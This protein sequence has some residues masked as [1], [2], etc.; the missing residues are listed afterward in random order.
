MRIIFIFLL[1]LSNN[2]FADIINI[3]NKKFR[4][5]LRQDIPVIDIRTKKE[6]IKTGVIKNSYLISMINDQG[7]YS[8]KDWYNKYSKIEL[9]DNKVI[10][11]C[12]VGGRSTYIS[13]ILN[14]LN[15]ETIIY[16]VQKGINDWINSDYPT[17][18]YF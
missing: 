10:I 3:D 6:W 18:K 5:L 12:A 17:E 7:K 2:V 13:S 8:L 14:K 11:I 4:E 16:N 15:R 1:L 9:K